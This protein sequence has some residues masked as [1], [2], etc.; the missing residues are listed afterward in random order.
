MVISR[1][2]AF[3]CVAIFEYLFEN[4]QIEQ[5]KYNEL[6]H[7]LEELYKMLFALIKRLEN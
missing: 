2:S 5:E 3:E 7:R 6:F 1:G 4:N